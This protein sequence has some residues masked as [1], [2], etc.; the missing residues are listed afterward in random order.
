[1]VDI[2]PAIEQSTT[3]SAEFVQDQPCRA[4]STMKG[5]K[6]YQ[7]YPMSHIPPRHRAA[8]ADF[9]TTFMEYRER[10]GSQLPVRFTRKYAMKELGWEIDLEIPSENNHIS[11]ETTS[12]LPVEIMDQGRVSNKKQKREDGRAKTSPQKSTADRRKSSRS[13]VTKATDRR[14]NPKPARFSKRI[15]ATKKE[16]QS[17]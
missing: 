14:T 11:Q 4:T 15:K 5:A 8:F 17:A 13:S 16:K 10:P 6:R 2:S 12:K 9:R 1:M 3:D 7:P